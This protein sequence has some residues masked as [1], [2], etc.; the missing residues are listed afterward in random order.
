MLITFQFPIADAR[1]FVNRS[2]ARLDKPSW[3]YPKPEVEFVRN[4]GIIR[5][6]SSGK[7][8]SQYPTDD[9]YFS[10]ATSAIKFL[11][12]NKYNIGLSGL[13]VRPK[14]AFRRLFCDGKA[15]VRV[16]IGFTA[17]S[18]RVITHEHIMTVLNNFLGMRTKTKQHNGDPRYNVLQLQGTA[19]AMS[20]LHSTTE[21][22]AINTD[23]I[24]EQHVSACEPMMV[25]E[26][27]LEKKFYESSQLPQK[28][29]E[30]IIQAEISSLPSKC[31]VIDSSLVYGV[32]LA[33]I[34]FVTNG[35]S[36]GIWFIGRNEMQ[37]D[38]ARKLRLCLF[39]LHAER[40]VLSQ[41]LRWTLQGK[42]KYEK[43]SELGKYINKATKI[44]LKRSMN[45]FNQS[46]FHN[47][48]AAYEWVI[49]PEEKEMLIKTFKDIR[50]QDFKKID[51]FA[52]EQK[53]GKT[54]III[55]T[56]NIITEG[57]QV[58]TNYGQQHIVNVDY[59]SNNKFHG[60]FI[61]AENI[62]NSFNAA[63]KA[64][65]IEV[66]DHLKKLTDEVAKLCEKLDSEKQQQV[67]H[68]L[69]VFTEEAA[70][71]KPDEK[72]LKVTGSGLVEAAKTV[73]EMFDPIK[74][75]VI[76]ILTLIGFAL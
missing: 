30:K 52:N 62:K 8:A 23:I 74:S 18:N 57:G 19:L 6:C 14:C 49:S 1:K 35:K 24:D 73:A 25:I 47:V 29:F 31:E 64:F 17:N 66:G 39:K 2:T 38:I 60:D 43:D 58:N 16:E 27:S 65:S 51:K 41:I 45:G 55:Q 48:L 70:E 33:Y 37:K 67:S 28:S 15:T 22:K 5:S 61:A 54:E 75:T 3:P 50:K 9:F 63:N 4:F 44:I 69:K 21:N 76:R 36:I 7:I 53:Y 20:Y 56:Q 71:S 34:R 59:G 10:S 13:V 12:F 46:I 42:I 26:F 72:I 68:K 11:E 32:F 40:Q